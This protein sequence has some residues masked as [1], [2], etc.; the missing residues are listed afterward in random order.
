MSSNIY[1]GNYFYGS[2]QTSG[3]RI[4]DTN[5]LVAARLETLAEILKQKD[6]TTGEGFVQGIQA[7]DVSSLLT[8]DGEEGGNVIK[9]ERPDT[10]SILQQA[11]EEAAALVANAK[12]QA[13][14][15]VSEAMEQAANSKKNVL[16]EARMNGYRE[17]INRANK[18][19]EKIKAELAEQKKALEAQ[20]EEEFE[21]MEADLVEII[22]DIYE[23]IF[24]VE[25]KSYREILVHLIM[26]TMRKV[27]G[28]RNFI[29]HVS[30]DD[31]PF[32][33]M[34]KKQI[35]AGIAV[36][37]NSVDIVEDLTLAKSEC[38]IEADGGIFECGLGTQLK[39]LNKK[40]RLLSYE[41]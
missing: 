27:E 32:V 28:S 31:Y 11:K 38:I 4:I 37:S 21:N 35:V 19:V 13:D 6:G 14:V 23:H 30:K 40:L 39:E 24:H 12:Q 25:L 17:G 33:S 3:K 41:K 20:Y 8:E 7:E 1:K 15:I 10:G 34:Q 16:E 9:A 26:T 29:V 2:E 5:E 18:E 36:S 22:T